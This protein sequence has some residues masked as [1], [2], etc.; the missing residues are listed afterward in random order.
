M[1]T[2]D[3]NNNKSSETHYVTL[4]DIGNTDPCSF[5]DKKNPQTGAKCKESFE[6]YNLSESSEFPFP[7]DIFDQLYFA[8]LGGVGIYILYRLME[9]SK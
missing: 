4:V 3:V 5:P 6:S 8:G 1:Q 2:V 9:K 7:N